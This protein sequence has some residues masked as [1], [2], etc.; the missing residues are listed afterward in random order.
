MP[1]DRRITR[2]NKKAFRGDDTCLVGLTN[3]QPRYHI[4]SPVHNVKRSPFQVEAIYS[5]ALE[6]NRRKH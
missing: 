3:S 1:K 4:S 6:T 5:S 2:A